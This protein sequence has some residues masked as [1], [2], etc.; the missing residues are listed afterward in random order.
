V[1]LPETNIIFAR[2]CR[3]LQIFAVETAVLGKQN[4][5]VH[6]LV[7]PWRLA[8]NS[9]MLNISPEKGF[10]IFTSFAITFGETV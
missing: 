8:T 4:I 2:F 10:I 3:L 6:S 1:I 9:F 7:I 5:K